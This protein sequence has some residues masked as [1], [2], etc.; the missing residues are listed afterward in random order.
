MY[1]VWLLFLW[2]L[3]LTCSDDRHYYYMIYHFDTGGSEILTEKSRTYTKKTDN[4]L[5][6]TDGCFVYQSDFY[7]WKMTC[8]LSETERRYVYE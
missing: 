8:Y 5:V 7:E 6:N 4:T 3:I 1:K 2:L